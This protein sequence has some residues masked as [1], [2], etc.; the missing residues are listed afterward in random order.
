[1]GIDRSLL[2]YARQRVGLEKSAL[3]PAGGGAP[4]G[5]DPSGGGGM[6]PGMDPSMMGGAPPGMDPAMM[7]GGGMPPGMDPAMMGGGMP[8]GGTAGPP[9][10]AGGGDIGAVIQTAM[11]NALSQAGMLPG[12]GGAGGPGGK[13]AKVPKPDIGT[14]ATDVFQLKKLLFTMFRIN[15]WEL[16]PDI[17]DGPNR[18]PMTGNPAA[19]PT[20]GSDVP[21]GSDPSVQAQ[22]DSAIQPIQ[23]MQAAVPTPPGGGGGG[24]DQG[25]SAAWQPI[26]GSIPIH[27]QSTTANAKAVMAVLKQRRA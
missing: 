23:P 1:M 26:G 13:G 24:G 4:P 15:G 21:P 20:G 7:G 10:D 3:V 22:P 8:P 16:P 27:R 12:A 18:D 2:N 5:M 11:T 25:K 6:P 19:S 9:P 17:L 14:I